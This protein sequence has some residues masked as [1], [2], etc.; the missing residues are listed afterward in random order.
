MITFNAWLATDSNGICA[1][2]HDEPYRGSESWLSD[3]Y[4]LDVVNPDDFPDLELPTWEDAPIKIE[5][6]LSVKSVTR[7]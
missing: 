4:F 3:C 7:K 6:C 5:L 1:I 2:H